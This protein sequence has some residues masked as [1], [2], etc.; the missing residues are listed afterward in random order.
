MGFI[1]A[2]TVAFAIGVLETLSRE[3][4][5]QVEDHRFLVHL[6]RSTS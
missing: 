2:L 6:R 5:S 4:Y 3:C 1:A